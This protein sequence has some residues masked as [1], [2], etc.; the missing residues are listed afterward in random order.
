MTGTLNRIKNGMIEAL[1]MAAIAVCLLL[2]GGAYGVSFAVSFALLAAAFA[3]W[4][5][6]RAFTTLAP[7]D[8]A[9]ALPVRSHL[10]W[11]IPLTLAT[12]LIVQTIPLPLAV[13][14]SVAPGRAKNAQLVAQ[15][16]PELEAEA[17]PIAID[18]AR[19]RRELIL[20]AACLMAFTL[21][22][23]ASTQRSRAH[24]FIRFLLLVAILEAIY[25]LFETFSGRNC[26]L[27]FP[28]VNEGDA[29]GTFINRTHFASLLNLLL[30]VSI[31]W[32]YFRMGQGLTRKGKSALLPATQWDVLGSRQGMTLLTPG[33]L[34]VAIV[35]SHSRAGFAV[36][37]LTTALLVTIGSRHRSARGMSGVMAALAVCL[38]AYGVLSDHQ[39]VRDRFDENPEVG[40]HRLTA[41]SETAAMISDY[42]LT[43]V[44]FANY[45][46]AFPPYKSEASLGYRDHAC[47]DWI[48][49]FATIGVIG[50]T[51][52][53]LGVVALFLVVFIRLRDTGPDFPWVMGA[54][55]GLLGYA[56]HCAVEGMVRLPALSLSASLVAGLI[57]GVTAAAKR[58]TDGP[59]R[60]S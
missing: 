5:A 29:T 19:S 34:I 14:E 21:G 1:T 60:S 33:L 11:I 10:V 26:V 9:N 18:A 4:A 41:W 15:A 51:P 22:L 47:S 30:P 20:L 56:C 52:V 42:T 50:M 23:H 24:R 12:W 58:Q 49:G 17:I 54:W 43:G 53:T 8:D 40:H 2:F 35:Q 55:C 3:L 28:T 7:A 46:Q 27:W 59:R 57:L 25:A 44:G 32:F 6:G 45:E 31:G 13:V 39:A 16:A 37:V 48:E 36:M 38:L